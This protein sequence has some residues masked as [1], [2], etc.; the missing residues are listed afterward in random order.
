MAPHTRGQRA[1]AKS[2]AVGTRTD[3]STPSVSKKKKGKG[4]EPKTHH[5]LPPLVIRRPRMDAAVSDGQYLFA[6]VLRQSDMAAYIHHSRRW[7]AHLVSRRRPNC[8][9]G[10]CDARIPKTCKA[11]EST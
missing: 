4:K 9:Q 5:D 3:A 7:K 10:P 6:L 11:S 2:G 8:H 1:T